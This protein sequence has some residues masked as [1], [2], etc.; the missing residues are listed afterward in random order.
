MVISKENL[1]I[2]LNA[3]FSDFLMKNVY[4]TKSGNLRFN[5]I[6]RLPLF[7]YFQKSSISCSKNPMSLSVLAMLSVFAELYCH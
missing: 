3:K 4:F 1:K 5:R 7:V 2:S 6:L